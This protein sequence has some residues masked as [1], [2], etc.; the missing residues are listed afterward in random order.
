[1]LANLDPYGTNPLFSSVGANTNP[2]VQQPP[3]PQAIPLKQVSKKKPMLT[4]AYKLNPKPLFSPNDLL[5]TKP[6]SIVAASS[7]STAGSSASGKSATQTLIE[8]SKDSVN[9]SKS[10]KFLSPTTD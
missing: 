1:P 9:G 5:V 8:D 2:I 6:G 10:E 7:P 4:S 3:V